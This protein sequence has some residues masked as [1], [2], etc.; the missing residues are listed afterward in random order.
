[1]TRDEYANRLIDIEMDHFDEYAQIIRDVND[2]IINRI[3]GR[4]LMRDILR[5]RI[6]KMID[7]SNEVRGEHY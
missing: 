4:N 2:H 5:T 1:M 3:E 6:D 7:L